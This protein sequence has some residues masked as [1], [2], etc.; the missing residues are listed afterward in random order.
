[1]EAIKKEKNMS[2]FEGFMECL[3]DASQQ[4]FNEINDAWK[5]LKEELHELVTIRY[6]RPGGIAYCEVKR[7]KIYGILTGKK[8]ISLDVD[9][10]PEYLDMRDFLKMHNAEKLKVAGRD[11]IA[12]GSHELD[13]AARLAVGEERFSSTKAFVLKCIGMSDATHVNQAIEKK[14]GF[15]EWLTYDL[16]QETDQEELNDNNDDTTE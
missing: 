9:G 13:F 6:L 5:E 14:F 4:L 11:R 15:F 8:I 10:N 16:S 2:V 3:S 12:V 1:M 7:K